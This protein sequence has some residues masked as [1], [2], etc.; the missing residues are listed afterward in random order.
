[1]QLKF[2]LH[3]CDRAFRMSTMHP[4]GELPICLTH[5]EDPY[6]LIGYPDGRIFARIVGKDT[7][8]SGFFSDKILSLSALRSLRSGS[9]YRLCRASILQWTKYVL[10]GTYNRH[11]DIPHNRDFPPLSDQ[12]RILFRCAHMVGFCTIGSGYD[13]GIAADGEYTRFNAF[14]CVGSIVVLEH[15]RTLRTAQACRKGVVSKKGETR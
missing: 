5:L 4:F 2:F 13:C 12:G 8:S 1:M 11:S 7:K 15:R 10:Y 6:L 9:R 14:G 3:L